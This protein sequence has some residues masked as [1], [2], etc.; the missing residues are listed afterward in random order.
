MRQVGSVDLSRVIFPLCQ[1]GLA[2]FFSGKFGECVAVMCALD[3]CLVSLG[4]FA[5]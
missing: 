3:F 1:V 4:R 5:P 2:A